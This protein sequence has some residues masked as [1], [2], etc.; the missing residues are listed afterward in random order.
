MKNNTIGLYLHIPFCASKCP[1]CDFYSLPYN[2]ELADKY[3]EE[4]SR[5]IRLSPYTFDTVYFGGG[6]PSLLK[7][8]QLDKILSSI[9]MTKNCEITMEANPNSA[10]LNSDTACGVNRLSLGMQSANE[11]E[12]K[13]LGRKHT[14]KDVVRAV[15]KA[16]TLGIDN[17]SLDLIVG[18]PNMTTKSIQNSI[19]FCASLEVNH[20]SSYIL[21]VEHGTPFDKMSLTLPDDD[22]VS[23]QYLYMAHALENKEYNQYEISNFSKD[24]YQSRH[25]LKYWN[26]EE[27]LGLGASAHS[28]IDGKRMFFP[29]DIHSF[30]DGAKAEFDDYGGDFN[31][32][33]MLKLRLTEGIFRQECDFYD[34]TFFDKLVKK[35]NKI[36]DNLIKVTD[37]NITLTKEGF[38]LS[39]NIIFTLIDLD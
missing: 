16:R 7:A 34:K 11:D 35:T 2:S 8:N 17:I 28:F 9:S 31:E 24:S 37:N 20:V 13:F 5:R 32:F 26:C 3:I 36:P 25:N 1:Y 30:I 33:V 22:N 27:Y 12:L 6:T 14:N 4:L 18:L 23:E 39:N 10:F 19:D 38:L 15:E 21:K 29:R